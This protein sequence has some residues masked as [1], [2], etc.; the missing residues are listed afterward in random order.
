MLHAIT[1]YN[2]KGQTLPKAIKDGYKKYLKDNKLEIITTIPQEDV[3][4][5]DMQGEVRAKFEENKLKADKFLGDYFSAAVD[6][7]PYRNIIENEIKRML[8]YLKAKFL[9]DKQKNQMEP[10]TIPIVENKPESL[11]FVS[12]LQQSKKNPEQ[13]I[14]IISKIEEVI[15][16]IGEL[17][18]LPLDNEDVEYI[19]KTIS[20]YQLIK[21]KYISRKNRIE[22]ENGRVERVATVI[23][24]VVEQ[25]KQRISD[26]QKKLSACTEFINLLKQQYID[27]I[28]KEKK[29]CGYTP[30]IDARQVATNCNRVFDYEFISKLN[31]EKIDTTYFMSLLNSL[32]KSRKSIDWRS[33]TE[34]ELQNLL[35]RYDGE[36]P[37]LD[38]IQE[39]LKEKLDTDLCNKNAIINQGMDRYAEMSTGFDSKVYFDLLAYESS[40]KGIYIIDQPE[41]NVSQNSKKTYLLD[42]FKTMGENRQIIMVTHNPQF[43]VN[44]DVDNLIFLAKK[45]GFIQIESGALEYMCDDYNILEIIVQNIDGGLD[46]IQKRWKRYEKVANV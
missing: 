40:K 46:T 39:K 6:P 30:N 29:L 8:E 23:A 12:N 3:F 32:L 38:T 20:Q 1:K 15:V 9:I 14:A 25:H 7:K 43:I 21:E 27:I 35:L 19:S 37:V 2:K 5:F 28:N 45:E 34:D 17:R 41:D 22:S 26:D 13:L 4:C 16:A 31:I 33:I 18:K 11:T 24:K 44:L 42:R 36:V 10:Y